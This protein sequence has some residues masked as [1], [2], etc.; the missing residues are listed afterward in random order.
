MPFRSRAQQRY[1]F[2]TNPK[3]AK[4]MASKT[5]PEMFAKLPE[6]S[7]GKKKGNVHLMRRAL[8]KMAGKK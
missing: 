5:T 6:K 8:E 7:K 4:E 3:V 1:L 2:A